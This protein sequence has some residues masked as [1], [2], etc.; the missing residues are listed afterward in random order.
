MQR[1]SQ[2][3]RHYLPSLGRHF[4]SERG[5]PGGGEMPEEPSPATPHPGCTHA[6]VQHP[7][8]T[9]L[10]RSPNLFAE[11]HYAPPCHDISELREASRT[12]RPM[13]MGPF[14]LLGFVLLS[15]WQGDMSLLAEKTHDELLPQLL[16]SRSKPCLRAGLCPGMIT[17][18]S[19]NA[20]VSTTWPFM[21]RGWNQLY[22]G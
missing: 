10:W 18:T 3:L 19:V 13:N 15:V 20:L 16:V 11:G 8:Q 14:Y 6:G 12:R 4:F 1:S 17:V 2:R 9:R 5:D 22:F 21:L 7:G